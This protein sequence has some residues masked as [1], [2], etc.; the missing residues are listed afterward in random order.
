MALDV[1]TRRIGLAVSDALGI[2]AQPL[3]TLKRANKGADIDSLSRLAK[4]HDVRE[5]VIGLPI[6]MGGERSV[7]TERVRSFAAELGLALVLPVHFMDERLTSWEANELLDGQKLSRL[8]RKGKV[9]KIAAV[10]ILTAFLEQRNG[11]AML[12]SDSGQE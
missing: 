4:Q 11:P 5:L 10:L 9:D 6:R 7:Q 2:T 12:P 8:Q 1:G 3:D